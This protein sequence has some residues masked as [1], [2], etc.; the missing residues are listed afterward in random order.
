[1]RRHGRVHRGRRS[2][3]RGAAGGAGDHRPLQGLDT[4]RRRQQNAGGP[5][6]RAH[7]HRGWRLRRGRGDRGRPRGGEHRPAAHAA[8]RPDRRPVLVE[9]RR[10]RRGV[11]R[12]PGARV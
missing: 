12:V 3:A 6:A 5:R 2:G 8:H 1:D 4:A 7:R 11:R 10:V 9:P